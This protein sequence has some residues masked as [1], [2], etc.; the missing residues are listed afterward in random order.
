MSEKK[1]FSDEMLKDYIS[2]EISIIKKEK[3]DKSNW[4][5]NEDFHSQLTIRKEE[6]DCDVS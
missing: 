5:L 4:K 3:E 2:S 6:G 1:N